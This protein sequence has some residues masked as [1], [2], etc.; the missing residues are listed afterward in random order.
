LIHFYK[1]KLEKIRKLNS[2]FFCDSLEAIKKPKY[3]C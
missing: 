2:K 3:Q 1:R